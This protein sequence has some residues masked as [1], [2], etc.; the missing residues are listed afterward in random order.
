[1][2]IR[3]DRQFCFA[4]LFGCRVIQT[5]PFECGFHLRE[6][7]PSAFSLSDSLRLIAVPSRVERLGPNC[8]Q[9]GG[10]VGSMPFEPRSKRETIGQGAFFGGQSLD[11]FFIP[12]S[13]TAIGDWAFKASGIGSIENGERS[14][15]FRV[16]NAFLVDFE[17][18]LL[19]WVIGSPESIEIQS[20]I[21]EVRPFCC[22]RK[23]KLMT[24]AFEP[25]S[26]IRLIAELLFQFSID[27]VRPLLSVNWNLHRYL[28]SILG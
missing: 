13:M 5:V 9:A 17:V 21:E 26:T 20:S 1:M 19:V 7:G 10:S 25:D 28:S 2:R 27:E 14:I 11:R 8:F 24:V 12:A 15:S 22:A 6:I 16:V 23:T 4:M 3:A 18:R